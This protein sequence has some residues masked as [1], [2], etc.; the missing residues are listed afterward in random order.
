M[1]LEAFGLELTEL[2]GLLMRLAK[3]WALLDTWSSA[4]NLDLLDRGD[5]AKLVISVGEPCALPERS[6]EY[7]VVEPLLGFGMASR[8]TRVAAP[9]RAGARGM[10]VAPA[11][12]WSKRFLRSLTL[13]LVAGT[14]VELAAGLL[15]TGFEADRKLAVRPGLRLDDT[16]GC[17][18]VLPSPL[19]R[20]DGRGT[21]EE[22][23]MGRVSG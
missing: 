9:G 5:T 4:E 19:E 23:A 17:L 13:V 10:E 2:R 8:C 7:G 12:F 21:D 20:R 16:G 11:P 15:S 6:V 14:L 1:D 18:G 3:D 22:G